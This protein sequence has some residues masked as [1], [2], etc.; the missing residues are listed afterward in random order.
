MNEG[1]AA[2][3]LTKYMTKEMLGQLESGE[4]FGRHFYVRSKNLQEWMAE[5]F[6]AANKVEFIDMFTALAIR[7]GMRVL[8]QWTENEEVQ[9]IAL[10]PPAE[11][12]VA[13]N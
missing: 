12:Q 9:A 3:Y 5:D 2:R 11:W 6:Y 8:W 7:R 4:D 10:G 1:A 13:I